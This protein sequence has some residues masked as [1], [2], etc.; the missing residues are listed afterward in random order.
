MLMVDVQKGTSCEI[1]NGEKLTEDRPQR[2]GRE[3][4]W[5]VV[6]EIVAVVVM[7][8]IIE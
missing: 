7:A 1:L 6:V 2:W 8:L 5:T 3:V 4:T